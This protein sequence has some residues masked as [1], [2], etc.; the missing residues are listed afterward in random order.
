M[1]RKPESEKNEMLRAIALAMLRRE[2]LVGVGQDPVEVKA[3]NR[4][5]TIA[6][7]LARLRHREA[8]E[9]VQAG[10]RD[11]K[12]VNEKF[13]GDN[14][15]VDRAPVV[16]RRPRFPILGPAQADTP[17][18]EGMLRNFEAV[19]TD[20][21]RELPEV[22]LQ[23]RI[24]ILTPRPPLGPVQIFTDPKKLRKIIEFRII[25]MWWDWSREIWLERG[26]G[27]EERR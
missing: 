9:S 27:E 25:V 26:S 19:S 17:R 12:M 8:E 1:K 13:V 24:C 5:R 3:I 15:D 16:E 10:F 21:M 2:E 18:L 22:D 7:A 11:R 20:Q 14:W 23:R 4:K 6:P